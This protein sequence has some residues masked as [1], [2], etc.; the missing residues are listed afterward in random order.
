MGK[1]GI[2]VFVVIWAL[3][4][5]CDQIVAN[6]VSYHIYCKFKKGVDLSKTFIYAEKN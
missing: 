3:C 4:F 1:L 6:H 5:R 2:F